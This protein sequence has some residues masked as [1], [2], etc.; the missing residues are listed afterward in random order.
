MQKAQ[1]TSRAYYDRSTKQR[2]FEVND[3]VVLLIP[4]KKNKLDVQWEGPAVALQ[5]VSV[6]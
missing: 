4:S 2:S 5:R 3:N 1:E 6:P